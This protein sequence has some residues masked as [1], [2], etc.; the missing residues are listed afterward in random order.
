MREAPVRAALFFS[1]PHVQDETAIGAVDDEAPAAVREPDWFPAGLERERTPRTRPWVSR[2]A[3]V[4]PRSW[5]RAFQVLESEG[6]AIPLDRPATDDEE[7]LVHR[8][9]GGGACVVSPPPPVLA[10]RLPAST[11]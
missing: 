10:A 6:D 2:D 7:R 1:G 3:V 11:P 9:R 5:G 4:D 8:G